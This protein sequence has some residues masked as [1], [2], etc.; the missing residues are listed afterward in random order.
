VT[1]YI[2]YRDGGKTSEEGLKKELK[3]LLTGGVSLIDSSTA[4][5]VTQRAAGANMTVDIAIGSCHIV[6]PAGDY[7][8]FGWTDAATTGTTVP[9]ANVSNPRIDT[10]VAYVDLSVV[11]SASNNNPGALKFSVVAGTAAG[12]PVAL[13]PSQIQTALGATVPFIQLAQ[14]AVAANATTIVNANI[15]DV[16]PPIAFK[17]RVWGGSS[18]TVGHLVPNVAD[19]NVALSSRTDGK[20]IYAD[21]LSTIFG[22]QAQ[23]YTNLGSAGGTF[24]YI[25]LGGIKLL[26]GHTASIATNSGGTAAVLTLPTSFFSS[27]GAPIGSVATVGGFVNQYYTGN[28]YDATAVNFYINSLNNGGSATAAIVVIGT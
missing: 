28:T 1:T 11:S 20:L 27:V 26:W 17:G 24:Q 25:N 5:Q 7:S 19:K 4:L 23:T 16:R 22:D 8:Y 6:K 15:T 14:L 3:A 2:G 13:T 18:N 9:T 12:S 10:V 21:L